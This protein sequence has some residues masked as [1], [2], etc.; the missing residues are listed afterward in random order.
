MLSLVMLVQ[1]FLLSLAIK[2]LFYCPKNS[3]KPNFPEDLVKLGRYQI[4]CKLSIDS[5]T[6]QPFYATTLP[7]LDCKN[8]QRDK[9]IRISQERWGKK[10]N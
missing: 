5:E 7:P 9:L 2:M 6:N 4:I 1:F 10:K 8:Q 3:V